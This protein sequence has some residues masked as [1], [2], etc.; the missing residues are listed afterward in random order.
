MALPLQFDP[1]PTAD[2][3]FQRAMHRTLTSQDDHLRRI[4]W[5][6]RL[7][8]IVWIVV[9]ALLAVFAVGFFVFAA[10]FQAMNASS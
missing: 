6:V 2:E 4:H 8:G 5:W 9:P 1:K 7:F 3:A 10:L